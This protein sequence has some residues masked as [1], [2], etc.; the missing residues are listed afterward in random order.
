MLTI[1]SIIAT[2]ISTQ[3][4]DLITK[5][6]APDFSAGSGSAFLG[7][8]WTAVAIQALLTTDVLVALMRWKARHCRCD[9]NELPTTQEPESKRLVSNS[10]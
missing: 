8:A 4:V 6:G 2:L 3:F 7:M 9:Y 10:D 1:G 5:S